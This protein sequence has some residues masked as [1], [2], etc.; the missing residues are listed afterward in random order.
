MLARARVRLECPAHREAEHRAL[1]VI[2]EYVANLRQSVPEGRLVGEEAAVS[3]DWRLNE[4]VYNPWIVGIVNPEGRI[5]NRHHYLQFQSGGGP[6]WL[7]PSRNHRFGRE[8]GAWEFAI[9][10]SDSFGIDCQLAGVQQAIQAGVKEYRQ[11]R[12][13]MP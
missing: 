5:H 11:S 8:A 7:R 6:N 4:L 13:N 3:H 2:R 10:L 1:L 9:Q 12:K